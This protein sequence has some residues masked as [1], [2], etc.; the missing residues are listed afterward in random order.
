MI[1]RIAIDAPGLE[2][3][4]PE[5][6]A[7]A[8]SSRLA[9][10]IIARIDSAGGAI[11][12]DEY[13]QMALYQPGYGYY[14]GAGVSFGAGGDF[15]TAPEISS[16]FGSCIARQLAGLI[17]QGLAPQLL[18]FG[19]G[20]GRL[21]AD[22]LEALPVLERYR[23]VDLGAELKLRQREYLSARLVPELFH[24]IEW[25]QGLPEG[26]DGIVLANE[27][28]DAMPVKRVCKRGSWHQLGV[29]FDGR[30]LGWCELDAGEVV[31]SSMLR[32]EERVGELPENYTSEI[33]M[34]YRAWFEA[35]AA[36]CESAV[37]LLVDY[38]YEQRDYYHPQRHDGT[39]I[40]HYR[41]R[42]HTDPFVYPGLQDITAFVDFDAC[43]DAAEAAGFE[44]VGLV[45]Q[46]RFLLAN[47]LLEVAEEISRNAD[48]RQRLSLAQQVS[49][50]SLPQEMGE[51][52]KVMALALG[53]LP[54]MPAMQ[55]QDFRG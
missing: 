5:A 41:H 38:G 26:F 47:G 52:F 16:L 19:A 54:E 7:I 9:E 23:I 28:L 22:I 53:A 24:K 17:G 49:T 6:D 25:L 11:G 20:S 35:L 27:V 48:S 13:M 30:R 45:S 1:S 55:R 40:C 32:I 44:P 18:E 43:A 2:L 21:C 4:P 50:L 12:F 51:K 42:V 33:N 46:A 14:A 39:L 29:G 36:A 10:T 37:A 3:P 31:A 34:R 8:H 15:V